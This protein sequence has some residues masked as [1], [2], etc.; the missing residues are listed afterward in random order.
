MNYKYTY[1]D[2][3]KENFK[4]FSVPKKEHN[5]IFKR[6]KLGFFQSAEYYY[7]EELKVIKIYKF[8]NKIFV[9]L[10]IIL[11]PFNVI[12]YGFSNFP[13]ILKAYKKIIFQKKYGSF[14][15]EN[16]YSNNSAYQQLISF[17]K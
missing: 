16:I 4:K 11:F 13:E 15:Q 1:I 3:L 14:V 2:P 5:K 6:F 8:E 9:T 7:S 10:N 17:L 12:F